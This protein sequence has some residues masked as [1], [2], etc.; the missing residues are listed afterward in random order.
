MDS[1]NPL[2]KR[3]AMGDRA[4]K[5]ERQA[6]VKKRFAE[7]FCFHIVYFPFIV[8]VF[9]DLSSLPPSPRATACQGE[10]SSGRYVMSHFSELYRKQKPR[11]QINLLR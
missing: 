11:F 10:L 4:H 8:L 1:N 9:R 5:H 3:G 7:D 6:E 2:A